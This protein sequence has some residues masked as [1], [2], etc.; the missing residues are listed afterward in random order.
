MKPI[1]PK[2]DAK[3]RARAV[4]EGVSVE[5]YVERI[6]RDYEHAEQELEALALEGL[7]PSESLAAGEKHWE[8]KAR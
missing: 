4:I 2:L 6:A 7:N 3:I 5:T 8:Q 1:R